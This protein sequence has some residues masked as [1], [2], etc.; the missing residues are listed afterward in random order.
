MGPC[1]GRTTYE[2]VAMANKAKMTEHNGAKKGRGSYYGRK[3][4]AKHESNKLR[5]RQTDFELMIQRGFEDSKEGRTIS[6]A[7]MRHRT[8][9]GI[10]DPSY[11]FIGR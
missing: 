11:F 5:R 2:V 7:E 3:R 4:D 10:N 1:S 6:N 9:P 8:M